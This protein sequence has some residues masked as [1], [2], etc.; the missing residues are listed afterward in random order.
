[1]IHDQ[2]LSNGAYVDFKVGKDSSGTP[3]ITS[4]TI[5]FNE[6]QVPN[7]GIGSTIFREIR[8]SDLMRLWF[9]ES[10]RSFLSSNQ[11]KILRGYLNDSSIRRVREEDKE[12]EYAAFAYFYVKLAQV[13]PN[14]PTQKL[15]DDLGKSVK[16]IQ[17]KLTLARKLGLLTMS[18]GGGPTGRA[19]GQLTTRCRRMIMEMVGQ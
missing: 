5:S 11:E 16:T 6:G 1:M 19:H 14:N 15:A 7:G 18:S 4:L 13:N 9:L 8:T 10:S 17:A 2:T 3:V 12:S